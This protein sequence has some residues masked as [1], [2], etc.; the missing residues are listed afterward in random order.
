MRCEY[1]RRAPCSLL[2]LAG[3]ALVDH[4][5]HFY[6]VI[7]DLMNFVGGLIEDDKSEVASVVCMLEPVCNLLAN[8]CSLVHG[9]YLRSV[10]QR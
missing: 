9:Q 5:R 7:Y 1:K 4:V 6:H 2:K 10:P 3:P 8:E